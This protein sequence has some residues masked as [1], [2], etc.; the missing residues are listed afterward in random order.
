MFTP[1]PFGI[2]A[3]GISEALTTNGTRKL[4]DIRQIVFIAIRCNECG[5]I[6]TCKNTRI[7]FVLAL[8]LDCRKKRAA[9]LADAAQLRSYLWQRDY[10]VPSSAAN[11][12]S[13]QPEQL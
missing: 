8:S 7:A 2:T 6:V 4:R 3:S 9:P 12:N 5:K 11:S 1:T 13:A 10:A